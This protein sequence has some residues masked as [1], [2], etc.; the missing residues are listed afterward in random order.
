MAREHVVE[1]RFRAMGS[2]AHVVVVGP[3]ARAGLDTAIARIAGLERR[4]SRFIPSSDVCELTRR[5]GTWVEVAAETVVLVE[6]AREAWRRT[7][8]AFDPTVLAAVVAAGYDR[9]FEQI[10][11]DRG[12]M[13]DAD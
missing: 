12:P 5:S 3:G 6:R 2:D 9:S 4:W 8:G 10:P 13:V 11:A 7:A 1:R